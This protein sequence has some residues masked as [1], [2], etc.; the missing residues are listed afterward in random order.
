VSVSAADAKF[1][2]ELVLRRSA[3]QLDEAKDYLIEM[4][5]AQLAN[6]RGLTGVAQLVEQARKGNEGIDVKIVEAITT[7]ETSF[8][9]DLAPFLTLRQELLPGILAARQNARSLNIWCAACSSGQEPYSIAMMLLEHFPQLVGWKVRILA[10]DLSEQVLAKA[11][12]GKFSQLDVNR[13][14]PA[15]LLVKYFTKIGLT[16][17]LKPEV[18]ALVEFRQLNL[19]DPWTVSPVSDV[20]FLRNVLIYFDVP[21]KRRI[22]ERVRQFIAAD[23]ALFLGAAETTLNID[24]RWERVAAAKS[25]YYSRRP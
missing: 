25:P 14:L 3:I 22:L 24:D 17:Q 5:L 2:R 13:G 10:T 8:F 20:I 12:E 16:W 21:T 18:R 19:I 11:R 7:H 23:G 15:A 9:R 4:R 6:D 1:V